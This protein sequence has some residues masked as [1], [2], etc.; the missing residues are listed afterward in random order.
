MLIEAN[1]EE[2]LIAAIKSAIADEPVTVIGSRQV[3]SAG[4][5]KGET[6]AA[7]PAVIGIA[8]GFRQN[9]AFTLSPIS[10]A[11]QVSIVTRVESDPT[12]GINDRLTEAVAD[13]L[14][15]WHDDA[16]GAADAFADIPRYH[17]GEIRLDG[18]TG[19]SYDD[20]KNVWTESVSFALRGAIAKGE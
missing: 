13:L 6:D 14:Q 1:I 16:Q 9:D 18:G 3:A 17:F 10:V 5:V 2:R 15:T 12:G 7:T 8:V 11:C 19:K 20:A 4:Y